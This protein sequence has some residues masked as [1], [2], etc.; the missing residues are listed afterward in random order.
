MIPISKPVIEE[1][2]KNAVIRVLD[3]GMLAQGKKV[4]EFEKKFAK[5]IG[6]N[7]AVATSSGTA[8]LH[9]ALLA[10]GLKGKN[11]VITTPFSFIASSDAC[12]FVGASPVFTDI[13]LETFNLDPLLVEEKITNETRAILIVHLFGNPCRMDKIIPVVKK[14]NLILIEDCCQAHGAEFGKKKVGSFGT[15]CFSFYATKNMTTGEGGMLTTNEESIAEKIRL[16]RHHGSKI[17]Y[18]SKI[19]GYNFCMTDIQAAMGIE[20]L[21]KLDRFNQ[22]RIKNAQYLT[23]RLKNIEGIVT[24]KI[25]AKT[26]HVFHQYT[27]RVAKRFPITR[28]RL[29]DILKKNG[30]EAKVFYPLPIYKQNSYQNLAYQEKLPVVEKVVN[31]VVS[32]PIHPLVK[33]HELDFMVNILRKYSVK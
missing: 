22:Q 4:E 20:Q 28:N 25:Y 32:L 21:Q 2:E 23:Q 19:L 27:I 33:K 16:L 10:H 9:L 13:E 15:G 17:P 7:Y 18:H 24:P 5:F 6:T 12:L 1:E 30:I 31:E 29:V 3:S 14:Y 8:A 11:E 26:K